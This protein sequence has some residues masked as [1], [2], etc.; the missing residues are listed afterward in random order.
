VEPAPTRNTNIYAAPG[1][2]DWT[3]WNTDSDRLIHNAQDWHH[4]NR[5]YTGSED[6]DNRRPLA[7]VPDTVIVWV[8]QISGPGLRIVTANWVY[9]PYYGGAVGGV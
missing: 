3:A 2:D 7:D 9:E 5:Y 8:R 6:L 4:T 1:R